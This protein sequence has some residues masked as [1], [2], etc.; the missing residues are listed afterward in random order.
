MNDLLPV[1]S[2]VTLNNNKKVLIIGYS[3]Y[4]VN[5]EK[6]YDYVCCST[7]G[8]T[9]NYNLIK[10]DKDLYYIFKTDIKRVMFIGYSDSEFDMFADFLDTFKNNIESKD[11]LNEDEMKKI[12]S[13]TLSNFYEKVR[14]K[15]D[16]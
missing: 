13:D 11:N 10:P 14:K 7:S 12:F 8:L 9:K 5:D 3:P 16:K 6:K 1:G 2:I 4:T 15:N